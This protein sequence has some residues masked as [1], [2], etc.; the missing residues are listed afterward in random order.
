MGTLVARFFR[1]PQSPGVVVI[2][3]DTDGYLW[4]FAA[5]PPAFSAT[6]VTDY[7]APTEDS[8]IPGMYLF[9][10]VQTW[11]GL[12]QIFWYPTSAKSHKPLVLSINL[13]AGAR[14][15]PYDD[16]AI[17]VRQEIDSNS[18]QLAAIIV[19]TEDL[20]AQ[21]GTDGAGLTALPWNSAWDAEVQS[22][23]ADAANDIADALL[24]RNVSG[25]SSSGRTVKQALHALRNRVVVSSGTMTVYDTDDSS[26]SW[27]ASV[28]GTAGADP[29]TSIDPA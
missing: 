20:Q 12:Y 7:S 14:D 13:T 15:D 11:T 5:G 8:V 4:D 16:L 22:E 10:L 28:V 9:E 17:S 25:G 1:K 29:I 27:T 2:R 6:P 24:A 21:I 18:T 19:D 3:R 23:C 26:S